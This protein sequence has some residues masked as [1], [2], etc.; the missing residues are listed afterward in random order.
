M[1]LKPAISGYTDEGGTGLK[2]PEGVSC[3]EKPLLVVADTG[4]GRLIRFNFTGETL[5]PGSEISLPQLPYPIRV[6]M[7]SIGDIFVLDGKHRKIGRI[8]SGGEFKGYIDFSTI[9]SQRGIVP[10]SMTIDKKDN[11]YVLDI[12]SEKVIVLQPDGK[13]QREISFPEDYG[14][15]SDLTVD[16]SGNLYIIDSTGRRVY[17]SVAGSSSIIPL[18]ESLKE[19]VDFPVAIAADNRGNLFLVDQNGSGIVILGR[20]GS[21]RGRQLNLGWKEGLLHYPSQICVND[22]GFIFIADRGNSRIQIYSTSQ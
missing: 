3:N 7:N 12:S 22:N 10:K 16:S 15:F 8:S 2:H 19:D 13:V 11:L 5:N 9:T 18:T 21:F 14:F 1:K 6:Q 20:D 17:T 4:N